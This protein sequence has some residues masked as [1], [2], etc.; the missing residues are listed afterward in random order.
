M[1]ACLVVTLLLAQAVPVAKTARVEGTVVSAITGAPLKKAEVLLQ[2]TDNRSFAASTDAQGKFIFE[3]LPPGDYGLS[4]DRVGYLKQVA[5]SE[6]ELAAGTIVKDIV[7]KLTPQGV[8]SGRV[9]D[10]EGDPVLGGEVG[11]KRVAGKRALYSE[12]TGVNGEGGF[13]FT[14]LKPG[15]YYLSASPATIGPTPQPGLKRDE[16][17]FAE[18]FYPSA[19]DQANS[20]PI[21]LKP[22]GEIRN[23]EIRFRKE[24]V[25]RIRGKIVGADSDEPLEL[26]LAA[27]DHTGHSFSSRTREGGFEFANV[28]AGSYWIQ[29]KATQTKFDQRTW[30]MTSKPQK[31]FANFP[32]E[33]SGKNVED[34]VVPLAPGAVIIG[35]LIS[36]DVKVDKPI[37]VSLDPFIAFMRPN[38][39]VP[40]SDG[41]FQIASLPPDRFRVSI[42]PIPD[43]AYVK[44]VRLNTQEVV[45]KWVDLTSGLG[46]ALEI[47]LAPNAAEISGVVR[48]KDGRPKQAGVY[49]WLESAIGTDEPPQFARAGKDGTFVLRNLPPGEYRIAALSGDDE[50][51]IKPPDSLMTKVTLH[52]GSREHIDLKFVSLDALDVA[53]A[54]KPAEPTFVSAFP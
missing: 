52:E 40:V 32:V 17:A 7:M 38:P 28:P 30:S 42:S 27:R 29:V 47:V 2:T 35:K 18:T 13:T 49:A 1:M 20:V 22:G 54:V 11:I 34:V 25:F 48:N 12:G 16:E 8:I 51:G 15:R 44:S 24:R 23:L 4:V 26:V 6:V 21:D 39:D 5:E 31:L 9:V 46:G 45:D 41:T 43:G 37:R 19:S 10:E 50:E 36:D 3:D 14:G 33:I 53:R